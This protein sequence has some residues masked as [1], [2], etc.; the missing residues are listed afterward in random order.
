MSK[1]YDLHIRVKRILEQYPDA[2]D[3][4]N[5]LFWLVLKDLGKDIGVDLN[6]MRL[7][8]V[9]LR[10]RELGLPQYESITRARRKVQE[11]NPELAGSSTVQAHRLVEE[12]TYK[13]YARR[14]V[15]NE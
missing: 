15:I 3:S 6:A 14:H 12:Q 5:V 9:I 2:R 10:S 7:Q 13:D 8:D 4:N 1:M 11:L